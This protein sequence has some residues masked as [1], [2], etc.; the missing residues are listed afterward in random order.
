MATSS[1]T[2]R[3]K[4]K[5]RTRT[6][7]RKKVIA[8]GR[9]TSFFGSKFSILAVVLVVGAVGVYLLAQSGALAFDETLVPDQPERGLVYEG[10]KVKTNGPCAGGFDTTTPADV[11]KNGNSVRHCDHLDPSPPG[12]DIRDRI[13]GVDKDLADLAAY[14]EKVKP[15]ASDDTSGNQ[16]PPMADP[17]TIGQGSMDGIGARNAPCFGTGQDGARVY[18]LYLY[19]S[20]GVNRLPD[21]RPGFNAIAARV[22]SIFYESG[23]SSGNAHQVRFATNNGL[24]G[25]VPRIV[26]VAMPA[27]IMNDATAMTNNLNSRGYASNDRKYLSWVDKKYTDAAGNIVKCGQGSL[28]ID[29]S[30]AST[31]AN[32][33]SGGYAWVWKGCWNYGEPHELTHMLGAVQGRWVNPSTG[34]VRAGA[35]YSTPGMHCYDGHDVMCYNDGTGYALQSIC[36]NAIAWWRLDCGKNTYFRG[37]SP[38][39]GYLSNHWNVANNRFI[40]R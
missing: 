29:D 24:A 12:Q 36:T 11:A 27:S 32:N 7:T 38:T 2:P 9:R 21:L 14:D 16:Q 34:A 10:K 22:N 15:I 25:C 1:K 26:A 37:N 31:N 17:E 20:G 23:Y 18:L 4:S 40:T 28:Y 13:K 35:P 39:T 3:S 8:S 19:P 33:T 5:P 30:P 6:A